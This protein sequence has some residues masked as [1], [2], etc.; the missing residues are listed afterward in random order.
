[1]TDDLPFSE[2]VL[3]ERGTHVMDNH[4]FSAW[5]T[6]I[7]DETDMIEATI[8]NPVDDVTRTP[9]FID[10]Q[11]SF[12][13]LKENR[14]IF[15]SPMVNIRIEFAL[16]IKA[17]VGSLVFNDELLK[18]ETDAPI[19]ADNDIGADPLS[20]GNVTTRIL[21]S[22]VGRIIRRAPRQLIT[23][24]CDEALRNR[25][26][27]QE[28]GRD[29]LLDINIKAQGLVRSFPEIR[30]SMEDKGNIQPRP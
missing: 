28:Q 20:A 10:G 24:G 9:V 11:I 12:L 6:A 5:A 25:G 1:M 8:E 22:R 4:E 3:F 7:S 18:V 14:H 17:Q 26:L 21:Q 29:H 13:G 2:D 27:E 19:R 30:Q 15:D 23:R 16:R